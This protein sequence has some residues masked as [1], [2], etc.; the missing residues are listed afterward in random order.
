[1]RLKDAPIPGEAIVQDISTRQRFFLRAIVLVLILVV[2]AMF[3]LIRRIP[4]I[5]T[6]F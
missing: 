4:A 3:G 2:L 6:E 5:S 1:M